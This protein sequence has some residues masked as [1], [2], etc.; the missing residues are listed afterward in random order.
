MYGPDP[1]SYATST[2][3]GNVATNAGGLRCVAHGVTADSVAGLEVVL[4]DGRVMRTG[5]STRKNVA[6][7]DLTHLFVGS[8][9]TLGV[10]CEVVLRLTPVPR[11]TRRC[12]SARFTSTSDAARAVSSVMAG[13]VTPTSLELVDARSLAH[14]ARHVDGALSHLAGA[15]LVGDVW[16]VDADDATRMLVDTFRRAGALEVEIGSDSAL[17]EARRHVGAALT[18]AGLWYSCDVAVPVSSLPLMFERLEAFSAESGVEVSTVAHA[19]D[20]N[21]HATLDSAELDEAEAEAAMDRITLIATGLGGTVS[22]EHGIGILKR[23]WLAGSV[24]PVALDAM[25][26]IKH[27]LDPRGILSPGR[28]I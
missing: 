2:I 13:P 7:Y 9:G 23:P 20:G 8:E 27:A 3:G 4:A 18:A 14:I 6:G 1:A 21:L 15:T 16:E 12:F 26:A 24:D 10:V 22:G 11:G 17:L 5:G 25:R 19:G 28:S